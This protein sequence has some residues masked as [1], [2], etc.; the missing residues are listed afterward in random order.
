M[1]N[2]SVKQRLVGAVVLVALAIIFIP[3]VLDFRD[4]VALESGGSPIPARPA[5]E[6]KSV[7]IPL[8]EWS[9][10]DMSDV[11]A[12][13]DFTIAPAVEVVPD[14]GED[15]TPQAEAPPARA[16]AAT[17][18]PANPSVAKAEPAKPAAPAKAPAPA[19]SVDANDEEALAWVIQVGSFA[20]EDNAITLR[21]RLRRAGYA[22]FVEQAQAG[23]RTISRV[24]VGPEPS[25][26]EAEKAKSKLQRELQLNAMVMRYR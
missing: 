10:K 14:A 24:R 16:E 9:G 18:A 13:Q 26:D 17:A 19:G 6:L 23:G 1:D 20:S 8:R 12:E 2:S 5:G 3:M 21:D 15:A 4:D 22:A 7:E 11:L 25:R